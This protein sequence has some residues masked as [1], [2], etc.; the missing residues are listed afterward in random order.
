[1]VFTQFGDNS[2]NRDVISMMNRQDSW[3]LWREI[4]NEE[5]LPSNQENLCILKSSSLTGTEQQTND[6]FSDKWGAYEE[7]SEKEIWYQMQK[8]WY[9]RLYGFAS[10]EEFGSFLKSK[11]IIFDAGCGL[12]YKA[13]W[14]AKLAPESLVVGIDYSEAVTIAAQ[15]YLS[16]SNLLFAQGDI[17][18][19]PFREGR[20]DYVSCDQVIM[21]TQ[22]PD[23]T[24][25]ELVRITNPDCGEFACY[26]YAKKALPREL[27]DDHFRMACKDMS[28]DELWDMSKQLTVLG[29][30]LSD[31]N[32]SVEVPDIPSLGLKGGTYD[33][34]RFIYWNFLKCFWNEHLGE[35]TSV[36]TNYDWYSPSNARR[37]SEKEVRDLVEANGLKIGYFHQEEACHSGRFLKAI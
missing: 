21:H 14:F 20:I 2:Q 32:V 35:E 25:R 33:I 19:V 30:N 9:L 3:K 6:A 36:V 29:K 8:D 28:K 15:N 24:F 31:L 18:E 7:S 11:K 23:E 4:S 26:F 5:I 1:M 12:G 34:Q 37:Y 22:N 16:Y 13:A 17:A 10:E 27:L